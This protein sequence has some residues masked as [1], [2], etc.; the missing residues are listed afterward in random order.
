MSS[1]PQPI[2]QMPLEGL[3]ADMAHPDLGIDPD[4]AAHVRP[5]PTKGIILAHLVLADPVIGE[6]S[7]CRLVGGVLVVELEIGILLDHRF[8]LLARYLEAPGW[9]AIDLKQASL[10]IGP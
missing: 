6:Q 7:P 5:S 1:A 2:A 8:E 3:E 4:L 10:G 9:D